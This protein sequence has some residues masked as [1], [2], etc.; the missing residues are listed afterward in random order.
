MA[1]RFIFPLVGTGIGGRGD[2]FLDL[3]REM[4][5]LFEDA[6][7]SAGGSRDSASGQLVGGP[8]MD[9]H[10]T[11]AALEITAELPGVSQGDVDLRI[12]GDVLTIRGEKR[13]ERRDKHAHVI[14]RS[15]GTF[16]RSLQLPFSP[17][18]ERVEASS[19]NGVLAITVPKKGQQ[20]KAHR[21]EVRGSKSGQK[22][23]EGQAT[24]ETAVV[25]PTEKQSTESKPSSKK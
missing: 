9:I 7:R 24:P 12:E 23:I 20:E 2:P 4:N 13:N 22:N 25:R 1:S 17:D 15:Y 8:R 21:I 16:Q 3:H 19:E 6:S 14:E 11:D 10:E 18:P 5:R